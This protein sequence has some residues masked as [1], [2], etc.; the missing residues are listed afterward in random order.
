M[1]IY[2]L[3]VLADIHGNLP[4]FEAVIEALKSD[5]P[6]DGILGASTL[7]DLVG[8]PSQT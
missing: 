7:Y 1:A 3:A 4:A 2:R 8:E 6:L 5:E